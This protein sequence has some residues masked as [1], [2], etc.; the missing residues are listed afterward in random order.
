MPME[1][2]PIAIGVKKGNTELMAKINKALTDMKADGTLDALLK[3][4]HFM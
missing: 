4:W 3:K 2:D 1:K